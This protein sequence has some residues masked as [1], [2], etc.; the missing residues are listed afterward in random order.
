MSLHPADRL[1]NSQRMRWDFGLSAIAGETCDRGRGHIDREQQRPD[2]IV[3][4]PRQIGA[5]F[6]L[7]RQQSLVQPVVMR[8][9]RVEP[10]RHEIEAARQS[11]QFRRTMHRQRR[12]TVI[13]ADMLESG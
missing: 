12:G 10:P 2:F 8:R 6:R 7:Q 9:G 13:L 5:L 11:H 1:V 4:V 3:Q